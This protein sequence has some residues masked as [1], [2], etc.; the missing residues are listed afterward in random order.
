MHPE[1]KPSLPKELKPEHVL[2][3]TVVI[4][5][6]HYQRQ[7]QQLK[8]ILSSFGKLNHPRLYENW[9]QL[10]AQCGSD[11]QALR[12]FTE[13]LDATLDGGDISVLN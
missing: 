1:N 11:E 12:F 3:M 2:L 5:K 7:E 9:A 6:T 10:R 8:E 13:W 4:L